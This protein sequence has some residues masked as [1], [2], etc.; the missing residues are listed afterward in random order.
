MSEL[1]SGNQKYNIKKIDK[2]TV[3]IN[4]YE[5]DILASIIGEFNENLKKLEKLTSTNIFFRGNTIT[6][7]GKLINIEKVSEA[8][9][10][11]V[12][13]FILTKVIEKN[14][15]VSSVKKNFIKDNESNIH[16]LKQLIN[17]RL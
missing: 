3:I 10:F 1:T 5:N 8:I 17:I 6:V 11:L 13:K 14:D 15:I 2:Q 9:K 12:D 16:S 4:I 7:K